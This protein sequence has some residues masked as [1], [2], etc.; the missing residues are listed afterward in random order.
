M[1]LNNHDELKK[2]GNSIIES[3][4][5]FTTEKWVDDYLIYLYLHK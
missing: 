2:V 1:Y 5:R 3:S 4:L